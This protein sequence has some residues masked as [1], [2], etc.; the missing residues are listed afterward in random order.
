MY[1]GKQYIEII[2]MFARTL[3]QLNDLYLEFDLLTQ[4]KLNQSKN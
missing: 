2:K 3:H 4:W 1:I